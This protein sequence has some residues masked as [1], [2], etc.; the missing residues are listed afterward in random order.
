M[1]PRLD[2]LVP[3]AAAGP[4]DRAAREWIDEHGWPKRRDELW[5]YA[6]LDAIQAAFHAGLGSP[7]AAPSEDLE[8]RVGEHP[9]SAASNRLVLINGVVRPERSHLD[10]AAGVR[11]DPVAPTRPFDPTTATDAFAVLNQLAGPTGARIEVDDDV[12][13]GEFHVLYL[14]VPASA[15]H[16][17]HPHLEVTVGAR[18]R[19]TLVETY[20][21]DPGVHFTNARSRLDVGAQSQVDHVR[22]TATRAESAHVGRTEA[23]LAAG[24]RLH[25]STPTFGA[26]ASR[27]ALHVALVGRGAH[28]Q[29]NGLTVVPT[30]AHHDTTVTVA[31]Q[32]D[33]TTSAQR[34]DAIVADRARSSFTGHVLVEAGTA[35][36]NADQVNHNLLVGGRARAD[37]RPWLEIRSD[38]VACTH[39]ATVGRVDG[40]AL[41]YMRSRGIPEAAART[42]LLE[43][44]AASDLDEVPVASVRPWLTAEIG[45]LLASVVTPPPH[46]KGDPT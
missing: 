44:F 33:A 32:G 24:A 15:P 2:D 4:D 11:F 42:M 18:S 34:F 26:G 7:D 8:H 30:G 10:L 36:T 14:G 37:T 1:T 29:L 12:D 31:H 22:I 6:P 25:V 28:T 43:A 5:R 16:T 39:G 38:D 46:A 45:A 41:F 27:H 40:D 35:G 9:S 21:D 23:T 17:V 13:A 3:V 19:L 20:L